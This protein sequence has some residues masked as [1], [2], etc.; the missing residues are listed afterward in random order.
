MLLIAVCALPVEE[1]SMMEDSIPHTSL[2][3][4][5]KNVVLGGIHDRKGQRLAMELGDDAFGAIAQVRA[6]QLQPVEEGN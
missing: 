5:C 3:L 6:T 2:E 1:V 4:Q